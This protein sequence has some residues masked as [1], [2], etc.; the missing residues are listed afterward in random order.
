[1]ATELALKTVDLP[2]LI[3]SPECVAWRRISLGTVKHPGEPERTY[4][5]GGLTLTAEQRA[6]IKAKLE[7]IERV[8]SAD[9]G[10]E[11]RKAR[12]GVVANMLL[13][14]PM[15][16]GSEEAGRAR[17]QAYLVALDDLPPWVIAETIKRWHRGQCGDHNYRFAP[18]P[19]E[20]RQCTLDIL[21]SA[22]GTADQL[23]TLLNALTIERAMDPAP[24]E[25][26]NVPRLRAI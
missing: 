1:M 10:P 19:A 9:D 24:V 16:G 20:L 15:S 14:Y 7:E 2:A 23:R 6:R 4:L 21:S 25:T 18:A 11:N 22:K 3:S 17:A 13:A 26:P 12:L 5:S 8:T